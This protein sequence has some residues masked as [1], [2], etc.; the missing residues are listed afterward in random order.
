M[1]LI[2]VLL[3]LIGSVGSHEKK[4]NGVWI[5]KEITWPSKKS[6]YY[7]TKAF[8]TYIFKND[9]VFVFVST[10][11]KHNYTNNV[12]DSL[13]FEGEPGYEYY[14]GIYRMKNNAVFLSYQRIISSS[15]NPKQCFLPTLLV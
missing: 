7:K 3:I 13:I 9:S 6:P 10:Q 14:R 15:E 12:K 11:R 2:V 5:P 8:R 4:L 1:K